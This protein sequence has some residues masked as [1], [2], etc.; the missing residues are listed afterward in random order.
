M[1]L[2]ARGAPE[3]FNQ[4]PIFTPPIETLGSWLERLKENTVIVIAAIVLLGPI[5]F[6]MWIDRAGGINGPGK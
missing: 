2:L 4:W 5:L 3:R 1:A 6:F